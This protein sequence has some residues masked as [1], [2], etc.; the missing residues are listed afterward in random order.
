MSADTSL[1]TFIAL[2]AALT[3]FLPSEIGS[4]LD[5]YQLASLYYAKV[6]DEAG[7]DLAALL[8][9]FAHVQIDSGADPTRATELLRAKIWDAAAHGALA[10]HIVQLWYLGR[11]NGGA[12]LSEA[13]YLRALAWR[14]MDTKAIG[15]SGF[16]DQYW[17]LPPPSATQT[18]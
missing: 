18:P 12:Y 2:S 17:T 9:T 7:A 4:P 13:S 6:N 1:E 8:A 16:A 15:F 5:P 14:A 10:R 3:G 11:W